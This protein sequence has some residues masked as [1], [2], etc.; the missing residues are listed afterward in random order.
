MTFFRDFSFS[1]VIAGFISVLVGFT[2]AGGIVFQSAQTLGATPVEIGSR[3]WALGLG[4]GL[5]SLLLSLRYRKP[6]ITAWSTPGAALLITVGSGVSMAEAIGA[7][8]ACAL[9]IMLCGFT[10]WFEKAMNRVPLSL[11]SALLAGVLLQF[12]IAVFAAMETQFAMVFAMLCVYLIL[13]QRTPRYA[14][15]SAL[16]IGLIIAATQGLTQFDSLN[17]QLAQPTFT[18][19]AFSLG[20]LVGIGLP[21]FFVTMASQNVPGVAIIRAFGYDT[22]VSPLIGWTGTASFLLAPFGGFA[23]NLAAITAAISMGAEAHEDPDK[24]Y[25]AGVAVGVFYIVIGLFGG[26]VG[27][28]FAALPGEL[29][30]VIAGLA[31]LSTIGTGLVTALANETEREPALITFLVTASGM[32]LLGIGSAFWGLAAG[33]LATAIARLL[34]PHKPQSP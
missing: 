30:S 2:G 32:T 19:P 20:A 12:G 28:I 7:F 29:V 33:V 24:R 22:P 4:M 21:L 3:I 1:A 5:T 31:L 34:N 23:M 11:A 15:L 18:R 8:L 9:L 6:V 14:V 25:V 17:L 13:R 27:A 10:G 16:A 26:T